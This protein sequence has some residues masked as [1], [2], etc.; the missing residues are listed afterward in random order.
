MEVRARLSFVC[1]CSTLI[2]FHQAPASDAHELAVPFCYGSVAVALP[3]RVRP[4]LRW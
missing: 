3:K 2:C 1:E 4:W